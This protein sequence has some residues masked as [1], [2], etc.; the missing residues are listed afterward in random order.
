MRITI[1]NTITCTLEIHS[2][3]RNTNTYQI[4]HGAFWHAPES[5]DWKIELCNERTNENSISHFQHFF[6]SFP[7]FLIRFVFSCFFFNNLNSTLRLVYSIW[8]FIFGQLTAATAAL[9]RESPIF[10]FIHFIA[11]AFVCIFRLRCVYFVVE[12]CVVWTWFYLPFGFFTI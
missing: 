4:S 2:L 1:L 8:F 7:N 6:F 10:V 5:S 12:I 3:M 9:A 11:H